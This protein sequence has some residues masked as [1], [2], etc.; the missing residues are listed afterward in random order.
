MRHHCWVDIFLYYCPLHFEARSFTEAGIIDLT[1]LAGWGGRGIS[2]MPS[3]STVIT[4]VC[5]QAW[6]GLGI[7]IQV[8]THAQQEFCL[9]SYL[10]LYLTEIALVTFPQGDKQWLWMRCPKETGTRP[11]LTE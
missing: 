6:L 7:Q 11:L 9:L 3:T 4:G 1:K 2:V 5:H 10:P 8:L